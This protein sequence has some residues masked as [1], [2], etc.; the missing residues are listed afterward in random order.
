MD[1]HG[2][3]GCSSFPVHISRSYRLKHPTALSPDLI[4]RRL[5]F[6]KYDIPSATDWEHI[7]STSEIPQHLGPSLTG[8]AFLT[9]SYHQVHLGG[10]LY[11]PTG[12]CIIDRVLS[13]D[14]TLQPRHTIS[15]ILGGIT[16]PNEILQDRRC[17]LTGPDYLR[18]SYHQPYS[19]EFT[20]YLRDI[21]LLNRFCPNFRF[22]AV[23]STPINR[24]SVHAVSDNDGLQYIGKIC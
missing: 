6:Y 14:L 7:L 5:W 15:C 3:R 9:W 11:L 18:W 19:R 21:S 17:S 8:P 2:D 24:T 23:I 12:Y 10:N 13:Q 1:R 16:C 4:C 22:S 20:E